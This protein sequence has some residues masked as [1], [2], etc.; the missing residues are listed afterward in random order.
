MMHLMIGKLPLL[1]YRDGR[2]GCRHPAADTFALLAEQLAGARAVTRVPVS[3][4]PTL[5]V[6]GRPWRR[7][8]VT[9]VVW[10]QRDAFRG[11][12]EPPV[13]VTWP[14]PAATVTDAFGQTQAISAH[15]G[16]VRLCVSVTPLF[17]TEDRGHSLPPDD[18]TA[19]P[20]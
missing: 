4:P 2:L 10:D 13:S 5:R 15:N 18:L 1:G 12:D 9:L 3:D 6:R 11:E 19:G 7:R 17:V 14:W 16:Q 20:H 8:A